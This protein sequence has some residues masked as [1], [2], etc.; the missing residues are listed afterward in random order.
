[1]RVVFRRGKK[2]DDQSENIDE[3]NKSLL[4]IDNIIEKHY[5]KR[6]DRMRTRSLNTKNI[7]KKIVD[8]LFSRYAI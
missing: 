5:E 2:D 8:I 4:E 3:I 7:F 1:M 6:K